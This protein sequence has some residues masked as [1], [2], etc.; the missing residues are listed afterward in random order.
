MP[1]EGKIKLSID[2]IELQ[3]FDA[4]PQRPVPSRG[5]VH[6]LDVTCAGVTCPDTACYT[7]FGCGD[8]DTC[9][10]LCT[11]A[12][13]DTYSVEQTSPCQDSCGGSNMC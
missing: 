10:S 9:T 13:C 3:S 12:F 4:L 11:Y 5:T 6:G 1:A 7:C 8:S 2:D